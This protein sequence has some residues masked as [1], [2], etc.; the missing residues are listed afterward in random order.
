MVKK[1]KVISFSDVAPSYYI[2][3]ESEDLW[4][5]IQ[6]HAELNWFPRW[7]PISYIIYWSQGTSFPFQGT[8]QG[9]AIVV[10]PTVPGQRAK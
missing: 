3:K 1:I 2:G 7:M 9:L 10:C 6:V 8:W 4:T 5:R